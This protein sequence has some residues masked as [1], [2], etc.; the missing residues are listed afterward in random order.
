MVDLKK[1][2]EFTK[3]PDKIEINGNVAFLSFIQLPDDWITLG[4]YFKIGESTGAGYTVKRQCHNEIDLFNLIIDFENYM[5]EL[6]NNEVGYSNG[7]DTG[8]E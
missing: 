2:Q 1:I 4:Y 7:F 5:K 3:L 8:I 6:L